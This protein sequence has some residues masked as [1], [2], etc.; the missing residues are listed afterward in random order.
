MLFFLSITPIWIRQIQRLTATLQRYDLMLTALTFDLPNKFRT[1][2]SKT[3]PKT[4]RHYA[5][6]LNTLPLVVVMIFVCNAPGY[7]Q[8]QATPLQHSTMQIETFSQ[9]EAWLHHWQ[10]QLKI[11]GSQQTREINE[12][13]TNQ[14]NQ[15][16]NRKLVS[17]EHNR[18]KDSPRFIQF[19]NA[20]NLF[21]ETHQIRLD[22]DS[23]TQ[24][25]YI[26]A[27]KEIQANNIPQARA[28]H[29]QLAEHNNHIVRAR[30]HYNLLNIAIITEDY[31]LAIK[32]QQL[33]RENLAIL[34]DGK[35][36]NT[37]I[38]MLAYF[39]NFLKEYSLASKSLEQISLASLTPRDRC[40]YQLHRFNSEKNISSAETIERTFYQSELQ[41]L[42][43]NEPLLFNAILFNMINYY[44]KHGQHG[45]AEGLLSK[46]QPLMAKDNYHYAEN[47]K[48]R[49]AYQLAVGQMDMAKITAS[50]LTIELTRLE[51][52][53]RS[54][55]YIAD[56]YQLLAQ[57]YSQLQDFERALGFLEKY[58]YHQEFNKD[59]ELAKAQAREQMLQA[60][61][62]D[63]SK[64]LQ[65]KNNLLSN[66]EKQQIAHQALYSSINNQ[67]AVQFSLL[68]L[69]ML[70]L[71][72][73]VFLRRYQRI[74]SPLKQRLKLDSVSGAITRQELET[75][76]SEC[77]PGWYNNKVPVGAMLVQIPR[78]NQS[79]IDLSG[80]KVPQDLS[81][82]ALLLK[83][84]LSKHRLW[85]YQQQLMAQQTVDTILSAA[86][87]KLKITNSNACQKQLKLINQVKGLYYALFKD[88][89]Y[90]PHQHSILVARASQHKFIVMLNH[91]SKQ[92]TIVFSSE[93]QQQLS[94]QLAIPGIK[95]G[96]THSD[97][98]GYRFRY[99]LMDLIAAVRTVT[100][101]AEKPITSVDTKLNSRINSRPEA[102][103]QTCYEGVAYCPQTIIESPNYQDNP[104]ATLFKQKK[105]ISNV[106][107]R[108]DKLGSKGPVS[109]L[110]SKEAGDVPNT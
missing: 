26:N 29:E 100:S 2:A 44:L 12:S 102:A 20:L 70:T 31:E 56:S 89:E 95:I 43:I 52:L 5:K 76:T 39:Y 80:E 16:F 92:E 109:T 13:V 18:T 50:E 17:I 9:L 88:Q 41:C 27:Q 3:R 54:S 15:E 25:T 72:L 90:Q 4:K 93:L 46:Y 42:T 23:H 30:A 33:V 59:I 22:K 105:H 65:L 87:K 6:V 67:I 94:I 57:Y 34:A 28:L 86:K 106:R 48:V 37:S 66:N 63:E 10:Q 35:T 21:I 51:E 68:T 40:I 58:R 97:N 99:I 19:I 101:C 49:F 77:L 60:Q 74:M 73:Y 82:N 64:R 110:T 1:A 103:I 79:G 32:Y 61:M 14:F 83:G 104:S 62:L 85:E 7:A 96:I 75:L 69:S 84:N 38:L 107:Y 81:E 78:L 11:S 53:K 55:R 45:R 24:W 47:L 108:D 71:V 98:S 91:V 8:S 36:K